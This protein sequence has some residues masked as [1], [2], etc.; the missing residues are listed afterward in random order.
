MTARSLSRH[1]RKAYF[2]TVSQFS[3]VDGEEF[4]EALA[5]VSGAQ[6][7]GQHC[8]TGGG[9]DS[10]ELAAEDGKLSVEVMELIKITS[11][12]APTLRCVSRHS[13]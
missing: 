10:R 6:K 2:V 8:S 4:P 3:D 7:D 13:R 11:P 5:A 9:A 12:P 1:T